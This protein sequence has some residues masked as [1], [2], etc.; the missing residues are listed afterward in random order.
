MTRQRLVV[1]GAGLTGSLIAARLRDRFRVTVIEQGRRPRPL[2]GEI[3]C[4]AAGVNTT[5]NR[6]SG[7]GG[8]TNYWHNALIELAADDLR[9][10]LLAPEAMVQWYR[11]AWQLFLGA[12]ELARAA[13]FR[14]RNR[15]LLDP[16]A[17]DLA[18]MVVPHRRINMWGWSQQAWPGDEVRVEFSR[19]LH[20]ERDG[21]GAVSG[22][23]VASPGGGTRTLPA[24]RVVVA[25]GGLATPVLLARS[26]G[27]TGTMGGYHDHPMAYVAK[28]RLKPGS[29]LKEVSCQDGGGLSLRTGFVIK[30]DGIKTGFY[31]RP[32]L[33]MR[34][35][36]ITGE[37]RYILSDLRNDP[38]SPRKIL[39]LLGNVEAIREG[40]LFKT[41]A[42][43][44][45]DHFSVLMLGEQAPLAERGVRLG[46]DGTPSLDWRVT[47]AE[48]RSYAASLG[49]FL[50]EHAAEIVDQNLVPDGEWAY[51]TAAHHSGTASR[52]L[53]TEA[54]GDPFA[55]AEL[56]G[57]DACDGSILR[58]GG[59]ANS[60]LT[61][62]ALALRL[63]DRLA[64][65]A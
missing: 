26:L 17:G 62:A 24:D 57:A 54:G 39:Q 13:A 49:R 7:L 46:P 14:D 40:I 2:T 32:A 47:P 8:T 60:G 65:A 22:V 34:T 31:L 29:L 27:V 4:T 36:S 52:F 56:P 6:G 64:G 33:S 12:D 61:L 30:T 53:S 63:A 48:H 20:L 37:A 23:R 38:F 41:G 58:S 9:K 45:G 10:G 59:V 16:S 44:R 28:L 35:R 18:E 1:I 21:A 3:S 25:A 55:V 50:D 15:G 19:A 5:I 11:Q 51:R 42:G 43:F